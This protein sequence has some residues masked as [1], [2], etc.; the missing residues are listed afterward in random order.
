MYPSCC[1]MFEHQS[2]LTLFH[3]THYHGH[4]PDMI[5]IHGFYD[6]TLLWRHLRLWSQ[7]RRNSTEDSKQTIQSL[8]L[9]DLLSLSKLTD[10]ADSQHS[11]W[12]LIAWSIFNKLLKINVALKWK[13]KLIIQLSNILKCNKFSEVP[14]DWRTFLNILNGCIVGSKWK[15][16]T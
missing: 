16:W 8:P 9:V 3:S 13:I 5:F 2:L 15:T 1:W 6:W 12:M 7:N 14:E 11:L 10:L 4:M